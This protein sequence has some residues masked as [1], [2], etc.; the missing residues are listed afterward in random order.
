MKKTLLPLMALAAVLLSATGAAAPLNKALVPADAKW[1]FHADFEAFIAGQLGQLVKAE[2]LRQHQPQVDAMKA[3]LG[4]DLTA[5]IHSLTV[6]GPDAD[7]TN[8]AALIAGKFDRQKL[9]A[10]LALNPAYAESAHNGQ[11]VYHWLDEKRDKEQVGAFAADN[12][13]VISQTENAVTAAL[14][15]L[16]AKGACLANSQ[17]APLWAM[18][19]GTQGAFVVIAA[20]TLSELTLN[21]GHAAV[22][23]NSRSMAIVAD[24]VEGSLRLAVHLEA[25]T[26]EAAIQVEQVARG[27]LAFAMLQQEKHPELTPLIQACNLVRTDDR[28]AFEFRYPS[29]DLF[30]LIKTHAPK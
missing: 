10:L 26:V 13:I 21:N 12:L 24:E 3:L 1:V 18:T 27:M 11:T 5:D 29:A 2:A 19:E 20:D 7:E 15:V 16:A 14:D 30:A 23:Q 28:L 9:L 4:C 6:F 22:L 8:A 17:T 25:N